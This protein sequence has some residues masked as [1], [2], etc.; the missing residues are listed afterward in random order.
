MST[1]PSL[2]QVLDQARR[3]SRAD[4]AQVIT[5]LAQQLAQPAPPAVGRGMDLWRQLQDDLRALPRPRP[6]LAEQF[7]HDRNARQDL[8]EGTRDVDT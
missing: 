8:I 4:Q 3:L 6:T 7:E 2:D 1:S 5:V